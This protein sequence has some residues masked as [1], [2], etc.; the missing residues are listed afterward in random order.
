MAVYKWRL[1]HTEHFGDVWFPIAHVELWSRDHGFEAFAFQVDS[2][3][4]VSLLR[5]S[6]AA[7][8]VDLAREQH[9]VLKRLASEFS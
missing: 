1:R 6:A 3:A 8:K 4:I 5:R 7:R 9:E 2:G